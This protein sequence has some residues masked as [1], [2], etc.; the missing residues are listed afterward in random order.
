MEEPMHL[1]F[2]LVTIQ[3]LLLWNYIKWKIIYT[4]RLSVYLLREH[5]NNSIHSLAFLLAG[6]I[7]AKQEVKSSRQNRKH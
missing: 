2:S 4:H 5:H 1:Y 6:K 3:F 7:S